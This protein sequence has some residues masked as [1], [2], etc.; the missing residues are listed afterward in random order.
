MM[1]TQEQRQPKQAGGSQFSLSVPTCEDSRASASALGELVG[2]KE[3]PIVP[4][5]LWLW[6]G[7]HWAAGRSPGWAWLTSRGQGPW[8]LVSRDGIY[9]CSSSPT[10]ALSA[11]LRTL[12]M[13]LL[14]GGYLCGFWMRFGRRATGR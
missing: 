12:R 13:S 6:A 5:F 4:R 3:S 10:P 1:K 7:L 11:L 14:R 8:G 9:D 2:R